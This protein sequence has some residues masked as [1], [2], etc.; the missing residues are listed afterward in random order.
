MTLPVSTTYLHACFSSGTGPFLRS[1]GFASIIAESAQQ[2]HR[3]R[4]CHPHFIGED[5]ET[6]RR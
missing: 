4:W 1:K 6:Q 3:G 5:S 2:T